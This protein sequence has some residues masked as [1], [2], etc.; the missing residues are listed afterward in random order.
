[1]ILTSLFGV[2]RADPAQAVTLMDGQLG[3]T[4]IALKSC[5]KRG[6]QAAWRHNDR[7]KELL[8]INDQKNLATFQKNSNQSPPYSKI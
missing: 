1:M 3:H 8:R 2:W 4:C 5:M 6:G 7:I